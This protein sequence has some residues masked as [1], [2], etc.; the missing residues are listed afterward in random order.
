MLSLRVKR[1]KTWFLEKG[2]TLICN[3]R[4]IWKNAMMLICTEY[5]QVTRAIV[6][7]VSLQIRQT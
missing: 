4:N 3:I 1:N 6:L 2:D 7:S 5:H